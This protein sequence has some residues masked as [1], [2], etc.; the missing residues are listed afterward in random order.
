MA[1]NFV[2][3]FWLFA[4]SFFQNFVL[5]AAWKLYH[6]LLF[7]VFLKERLAHGYV[8]AVY[9]VCKFCKEFVKNLLCLIILHIWC[10]AFQHV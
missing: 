7:L 6:A 3:C 5:Q 10:G 8:L 9:L 4:V 2:S 1:A